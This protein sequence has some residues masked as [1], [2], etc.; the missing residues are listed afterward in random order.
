MV[1]IMR[2][3]SEWQEPRDTASYFASYRLRIVVMVFVIILSFS[4]QILL[5]L[6]IV[7]RCGH[8]CE[9]KSHPLC[10]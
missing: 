1:R 5:K 10:M 3:K 7:K 6:R 2:T 4:L 8:E 9:T